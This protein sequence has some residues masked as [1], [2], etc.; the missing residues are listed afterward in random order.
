MKKILIIVDTQNDFITG[1]LA[2]KHDKGLIKKICKLTNEFASDCVFYTLDHHSP[3]HISFITNGGIW[4]EHCLQKTHGCKLH[5]DL[6]ALTN[7]HKPSPKNMF[8][9]GEN[10]KR[11][12]YSGF[13]AINQYGQSLSSVVSSDSTVYI[14]GFALEYCCLE[15][16]KDFAN[17]G[18][19]TYLLENYCGYVNS[20]SRKECLSK[21]TDNLSIITL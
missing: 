21:S 9:K 13:T 15:T 11:E 20:E 5:K 2:C 3:N 14:V 6:L 10:D 17:R 1:S 12:E 18:C 4:P 19:Q 7:K 8:Y 16:A